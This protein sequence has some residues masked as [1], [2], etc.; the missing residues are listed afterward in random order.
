L[1]TEK[2]ITKKRFLEMDLQELIDKY[3]NITAS[4]LMEIFMKDI[5]SR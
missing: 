1:H 2:P 3:G 5:E 4:Q